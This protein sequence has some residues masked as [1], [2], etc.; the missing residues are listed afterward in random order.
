MLLKCHCLNEASWLKNLSIV[1][2]T[3]PIKSKPEHA[4]K[5]QDYAH[6]QY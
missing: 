4:Y 1:I 6:L 5:K 3:E 2:N